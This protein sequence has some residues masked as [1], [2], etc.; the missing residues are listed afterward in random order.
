MFGSH[1]GGGKHSHIQRMA[2]YAAMLGCYRKGNGAAEK[3]WSEVRDE[4]GANPTDPS[5]KLAKFL[6]LNSSSKGRKDY[7]SVQRYRVTDREFYVK[8][9]H[10]FQAWRKEEKTDL[11]YYADKEVPDLR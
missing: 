10:A 5:R 8:V 4:T 9:I 1:C 6:L 11:K 7:N 3:F 2:V